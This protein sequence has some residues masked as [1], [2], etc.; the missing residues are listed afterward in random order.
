[1]S[2]AESRRSARLSSQLAFKLNATSQ[3]RIR[4][5][6][7]SIK[8]NNNNNNC[9]NKA[10][11]STSP[12]K[13]PTTSRPTTQTRHVKRRSPNTTKTTTTN[14]TKRTTTSKRIAKSV[15]SSRHQRRRLPRR[16]G[17]TNAARMVKSG[18]QE[19]DQSMSVVESEAEPG[20]LS[21]PSLSTS[22]NSALNVLTNAQTNELIGKDYFLPKKG[23]G[24]GMEKL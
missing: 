12:P 15:T 17:A 4:A 14:R 20:S 23:G 24:G 7:N 21:P 8:K 5:E 2:S 10:K 3:T 9:N 22:S 1:M 16:R 11:S 19:K 6:S 13:R 18:D